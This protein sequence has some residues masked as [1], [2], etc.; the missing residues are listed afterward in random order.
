[1]SFRMGLEHF[2][3]RSS[4][5]GFVAFSR[6]VARVPALLLLLLLLLLLFFQDCE[7]FEKRYRFEE[8]FLSFS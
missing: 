4:L 5:N 3:H 2:H 1:M 6:G 8:E 7:I